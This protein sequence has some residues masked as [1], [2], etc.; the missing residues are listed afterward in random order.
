[1]KSTY[2]VRRGDSLSRIARAHGLTLSELLAVNPQF[3]RDDRNIDLIHP[4]EA[5]NI[6]HTSAYDNRTDLAT[7]TTTCY[8]VVGVFP[9]TEEGV[10]DFIDWTDVGRS[11]TD[12]AWSSD[13]YNCQGFAGA[14]GHAAMEAGVATASR[15]IHAVGNSVDGDGNRADTVNHAITEITTEDGSRYLIDAQTRSVSPAYTLDE[16]GEIPDD[17]RDGYILDLYQN[18]YDGTGENTSSIRLVGSRSLDNPWGEEYLVTDQSAGLNSDRERREDCVTA[19][20]ARSS[21]VTDD[22]GA[23]DRGAGGQA[24]SA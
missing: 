24:S 16:D 23:T 19:S 2:V 8:T 22:S 15:M 7:S 12:T 9:S 5:V 11:G 10:H 21:P 14:M 4:G 3:S 1:M 17:I 18:S 13:N 6:P 20:D